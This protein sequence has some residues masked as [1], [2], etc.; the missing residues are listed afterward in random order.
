M[1]N[2]AGE[3]T[4]NLSDISRQ[5]VFEGPMTSDRD[6][7]FAAAIVNLH[8][9]K[10]KGEDYTGPVTAYEGKR[11]YL[12]KYFAGVEQGDVQKLLST[13]DFKP[14]VSVNFETGTLTL[15]RPF[16]PGESDG[17][18]AAAQQLNIQQVAQ[19]NVQQKSDL[20]G[21]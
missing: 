15:E 17:L 2:E 21:R 20:G 1:D 12:D 14:L 8:Q 3:Q 9:L 16:A 10:T 7:A 19:A 13:Q 18:V 6:R 4:W 5:A 11:T